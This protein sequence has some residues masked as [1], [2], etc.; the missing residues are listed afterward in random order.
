MNKAV[1]IWLIVASALVLVGAIT[2]FGVMSAMEWNFLR[3]S[4]E[5]Y[6]TNKHEISENFES[7]SIK[8]DTPDIVFLMS[9]DEKCRVE[10]YESE[11]AKHSV[12]VKGRTLDIAVVN[13]R[14]WYDNIYIGFSSA[15]KIKIYLPKSEYE[16]LY[17][18]ASTGSLELH[19]ELSFESMDISLSTGDVFCYSSAK[20]DII[21]K[22]STGDIEI[23]N[24]YAGALDLN[25]STGK[26]KASNIDCEGDSIFTVTTGKAILS[27]IKCK[28]L[29]SKGSTGDIVLSDVISSGKFDIKRVTGYVSFDGCDAAEIYVTTDTGDVKGSLLSEK[30]FIPTTDTGDVDVPKTVTGGRCEITTDT[31]DIKIS[32]K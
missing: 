26:I 8:T 3:L 2:F 5:K 4:T 32:I 31:G 15:P 13:E 30:I 7:I 18:K 1:K 24:I 11:K 20:N 27:D 10:C 22:T 21:I 17:V 28:D 29:I 23:E 12:T 9:N 6:E 16:E 19:E 14:K 25:S